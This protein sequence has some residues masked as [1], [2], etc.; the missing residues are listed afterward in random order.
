MRDGEAVPFTSKRNVL[1]QHSD[2]RPYTV[3]FYELADGRGWVHDF[4]PRTPGARALAE[5]RRACFVSFFPA[6]IV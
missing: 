2:G 3:C 1:Y 6:E 5:V 4:H